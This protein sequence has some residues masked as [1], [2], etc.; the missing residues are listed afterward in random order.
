[1][2][3]RNWRLTLGVGA[4]AAVLTA[5]CGTAGHR[6]TVNVV[7]ASA[8]ATARSQT[9]QIVSTFTQPGE[10][11]STTL[12]VYD[13]QHHRGASFPSGVSRRQPDTIFDGSKVYLSLPEA[14][15]GLLGVKVPTGNKRWLI[16]DDTSKSHRDQ[17]DSLLDPL[18]PNGDVATLLDRLAAIV[19][20]V[21]PSGTAVVGGVT[22]TLYDV[23]L[24]VAHLKKPSDPM[25]TLSPSGP[26]QLWVDS[27]DRV[28]QLRFSFSYPQTPV[29]TETSNYTNFGAP[30]T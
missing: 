18:L 21:H 2:G 6:E 16:Y 26:L 15:G 14:A 24:D 5:G 8:A 9:V 7:Q 17:L 20:S 29:V 25:M 13:Y 27:Q 19:E 4:L 12:L 28:R 22:T 3:Q 11:P 30:S 23:T 1:V 10:P